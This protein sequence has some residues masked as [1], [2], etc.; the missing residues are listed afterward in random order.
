MRVGQETY[1]VPN[2]RHSCNLVATKKNVYIYGGMFSYNQTVENS[3]WLGDLWSLNIS[4]LG[5]YIENN[6]TT[7][8]MYC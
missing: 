2:S 8:S 1:V 6:T 4:N 7:G 5:K 3:V